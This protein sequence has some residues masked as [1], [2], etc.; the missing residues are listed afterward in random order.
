MQV[1]RVT[2]RAN[3][4]SLKSMFLEG[5]ILKKTLHIYRFV[6]AQKLIIHR[7]IPPHELKKTTERANQDNQ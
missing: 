3:L 1:S 4:H 7:A 2:T 5:S 6:C